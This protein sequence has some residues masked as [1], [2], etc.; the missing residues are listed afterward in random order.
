MAWQLTAQCIFSQSVSN[1]LKQILCLFGR[2]PTKAQVSCMSCTTR[3]R[4]PRM[5]STWVMLVCQ[6]VK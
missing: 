4:M 3:R 6:K 1:G 2:Q 5:E